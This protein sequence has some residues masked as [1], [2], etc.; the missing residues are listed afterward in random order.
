MFLNSLKRGS[1]PSFKK[2]LRIRNRPHALYITS[3]H[4]DQRKQSP[5]QALRTPATARTMELCRLPR[6]PLRRVDTSSHSVKIRKTF[7]SF[8]NDNLFVTVKIPLTISWNL[9]PSF[10]DSEHNKYEFWKCHKRNPNL[11][12]Y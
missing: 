3:M 9:Y 10:F 6:Q 2:V 5:S 12:N 1:F 4:N 8:S 11:F 7:T